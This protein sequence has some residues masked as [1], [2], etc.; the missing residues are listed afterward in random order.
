[1][2]TLTIMTDGSC[3]LPKDII[4]EYGIKIIPLHVHFEDG[5][6]HVSDNE[7]F[8]TRLRSGEVAKTSACSPSAAIETMKKELDQ[9]KD[10]I[11]ITI[12]SSLSCSFNNIRIASLELLDS[13]PDRRITVIDSLTTSAAMGLLTA[14]ACILKQQGIS[15]NEIV[16]YLNINK[17]SYHIEFYVDELQYLVRGGRLNPA[18]AKIGS[19]ISIKPILTITDKGTIEVASKA[20][21]T[22]GALKQIKQ[23]FLA[24]TADNGMI[25]IVHSNNT[26]KAESLKEELLLEQNFTDVFICELCP[27]IGCHTGPDC[28]G[29]SYV[30]KS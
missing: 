24:S 21:K 1:M 25:C 23:R 9:G 22:S 12:S 17:H 5:K 6:D 2:D 3:D 4:K 26:E 7:E 30:L 15:Y 11:C 18:L 28:L 27:T 29:L 14:K 20:R 8:Y 10:I 19:I 16:D 13:Y